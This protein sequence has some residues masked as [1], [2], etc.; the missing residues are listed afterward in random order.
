MHAYQFAPRCN[1][2]HIILY[3]ILLLII[4]VI[5]IEIITESLIIIYFI[6]IILLCLSYTLEFIFYL[7]F[8]Y[9][10]DVMLIYLFHYTRDLTR[11]FAN[12]SSF[13]A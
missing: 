8:I 5:V 7:H 13:L 4:N 10:R 6:L 11:P 1:I 12:S 2:F 3:V 9:L